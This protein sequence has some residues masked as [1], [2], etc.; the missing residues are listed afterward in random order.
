L[1]LG[2]EKGDDSSIIPP[3]AVLDLGLQRRSDGANETCNLRWQYDA[4]ASDY[5]VTWYACQG[6]KDL[7]FRIANLE[8]LSKTVNGIEVEIMEASAQKHTGGLVEL[9]LF[10]ER[11]C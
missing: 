9:S 7:W 5:P 4:A 1:T 3:S 11:H 2:V 10:I 8:G 6:T